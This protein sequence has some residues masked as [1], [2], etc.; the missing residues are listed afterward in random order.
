MT[1]HGRFDSRRD[2][3]IG[4]ALRDALQP[5]GTDAFVAGVLTRVPDARTWWE[6][7]GGWA[8]PGLAAALLLAA[9]GG[10]WLGRAV[11]SGQAPVALEEIL[12]DST[13]EHATLSALMAAAPPD[14]ELLFSSGT[15]RD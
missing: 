3:A 10:F 15:G 14:V 12:N 13:T 9:L 4:R 8:R 2:L 11:Q 7:L 1:R 5:E 6:V